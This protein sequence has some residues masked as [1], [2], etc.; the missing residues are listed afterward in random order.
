MNFQIEDSN[1]YI[2]NAKKQVYVFLDHSI[3]LGHG[4]S[5]HRYGPVS[6]GIPSNMLANILQHMLEQIIL[7]HDP[8]D[9]YTNQKL[10]IHHT[11]LTTILIYCKL[12]IHGVVG[13]C[14]A[15]D[16]RSLMDSLMKKICKE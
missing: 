10:I 7:Y 5:K 6:A 16:I 14:S 12:H 11:N 3:D 13:M 8:K 15:G 4:V 2:Y 9:Y 1:V